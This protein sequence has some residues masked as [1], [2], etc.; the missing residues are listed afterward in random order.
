MQLQN[1]T[2]PEAQSLSDD[3]VNASRLLE[4]VFPQEE[5]RPCMRT[6]KYWQS[7]KMIPFT[8]IG[9]R[10]FYQPARVKAAL[11]KKFTIESR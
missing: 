8:R 7:R 10:S 9:K 3:F 5:S 1:Q 2:L 11:V 4:L 6:L